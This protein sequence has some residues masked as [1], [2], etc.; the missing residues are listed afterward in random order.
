MSV[1]VGMYLCASA[2]K[3][4]ERKRESMMLCFGAPCGTVPTFMAA[5]MSAGV[6]QRARLNL[7]CKTNSS[8]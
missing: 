3:E 6:K 1:F 8:V 7:A 2:E 4:R 5:K